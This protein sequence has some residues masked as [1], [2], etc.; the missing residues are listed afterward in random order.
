MQGPKWMCIHLEAAVRGEP[1]K[2]V[3]TG[4]FHFEWLISDEFIRVRPSNGSE[5]RLHRTEFHSNRAHLTDKRCV[6]SLRKNFNFIAKKM[7]IQH[8]IADRFHKTFNPASCHMTAKESKIYS[9]FFFF[10]KIEPRMTTLMKFQKLMANIALRGVSS[11]W[12]RT[13]SMSNAT[14]R[15]YDD[16]HWRRRNDNAPSIAPPTTAHFLG[17][18]M[19]G[20]IKRSQETIVVKIFL[21]FVVFLFRSLFHIS[22]CDFHLFVYASHSM[23]VNNCV[24][25]SP[26]PDVSDIADTPPATKVN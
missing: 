10:R 20:S 13:I 11:W 8:S 22:S 23:R 15:L 1:V 2:W 5:Q 6:A 12:Q 24:C 4:A 17:I 21:L 3:T 25:V 18:I 14:N 16:W 9:I 26:R 19:R 7:Q